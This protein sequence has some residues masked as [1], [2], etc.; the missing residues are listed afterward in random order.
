[1]VKRLIKNTVRFEMRCS[2]DE[3]EAWRHAASTHGLSLSQYVRL[4]L[5][6]DPLPAVKA[7]TDPSL[8]R[9]LAAIGN[10]LNQIAR[11][12]NTNKYKGA[13]TPVEEGIYAV[14]QQL[15][16]LLEQ[17]RNHVD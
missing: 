15:A 14:R 5:N 8:I 2:P 12:V 13:S 11:W 7:K 10:N 1:M 4:R 6:R 9:Q 16:L 17:E 3:L